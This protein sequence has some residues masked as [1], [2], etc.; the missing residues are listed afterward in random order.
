MRVLAVRFTH[1]G[2]PPELLIDTRI[3]I[4]RVSKMRFGT[5]AVVIVK[6][7][8]PPLYLHVLVTVSE[9]PTSG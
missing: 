8:P 4:L 2:P 1:L 3:S 9:T 7:V 6:A 5:V